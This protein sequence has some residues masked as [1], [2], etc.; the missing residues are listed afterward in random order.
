MYNQRFPLF[1]FWANLLTFVDTPVL[2]IFSIQM[3]QDQD[4]FAQ[5]APL[6][7]FIYRNQ[8]TFKPLELFKSVR[9]SSVIERSVIVSRWPGMVAAV[10]AGRTLRSMDD[11][12]RRIPWTGLSAIPASPQRLNIA[13]PIL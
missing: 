7:P 12:V 4:V 6:P 2:G 10:V 13:Q 1:L 5:I 9:A 8:D 11:T 3:I